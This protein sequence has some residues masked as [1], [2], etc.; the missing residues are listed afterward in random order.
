ML[1]VCID[2][3]HGGYDSGAVGPTGV[4]EKDVNMAIALKVR[5]FLT[6]QGV[7]VVLTRDG[8]YTPGHAT[9]DG[10]LQA[11]CDIANNAKADVFVSIHA[12]SAV[13]AANGSGTYLYDGS[14]EGQKLAQIILDNLLKMDGLNDHG[15]HVS[16]FWVLHYTNMPAALTEVAF[17][18]N[19]VEE[20]LLAS[21][22]FQAKAAEG[23]ARGIAGY[24]GLTWLVQDPT[25]E[26]IQ[27][28]QNAG[29]ILSPDYW[30]ENARPGEQVDGEYA[31]ILIQSMAKKIRGH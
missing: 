24:L 10:D 25:S 31:G 16:H 12:D 11:R 21:Q 20:K 18:S 5:D 19:P 7:E 23:I 30:L 9:P 4:L 13:A 3:G 6:Q 17:L 22:D 28:L 15:V 14:A 27:V 29:V 26:A 2:P 8:D 1:K